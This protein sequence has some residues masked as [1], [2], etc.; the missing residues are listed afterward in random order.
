MITAM[1]MVSAKGKDVVS[2]SKDTTV[3]DAVKLMNREKI[4]A[5]VVKEAEEIVGIWTERDL[6]RNTMKDS[7]DPKRATIAEYMATDLK[8]ANHDESI[9]QIQ[10]RFL[11]MRFRHMLIR[12]DEKLVGLLS[13]GDVMKAVL[14]DKQRELQDLNAMVSWE[15][16]DNW[17]W[18]AGK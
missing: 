8:F 17:R 13:A 5:V 4:G 3:L 11:G 14:N 9:Y 7:F 16:Y 12:K 15:Y 1:D 10:D 6:L 2:V 18:D